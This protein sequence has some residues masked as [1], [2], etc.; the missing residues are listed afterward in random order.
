MVTKRIPWGTYQF[1]CPEWAISI[2]FYF[3]YLFIYLFVV[4]VDNIPF[5]M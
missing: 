5:F 3:I 1:E 4:V 2:L